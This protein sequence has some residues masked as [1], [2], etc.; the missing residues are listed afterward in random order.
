[1]IGCLETLLFE[2]EVD[3]VGVLSISSLSMVD[4]MFCPLQ[5]SHNSTTISSPSTVLSN[6]QT[7]NASDV[8]TNT[9][10]TQQLST[11]RSNA[12]SSNNERTID[13]QT[14]NQPA[15]RNPAIAMARGVWSK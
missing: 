7:V 10:T 15:N 3:C 11:E 9:P 14:S 6:D 8:S 4:G 2:N 13:E 12:I 5:S 1:M